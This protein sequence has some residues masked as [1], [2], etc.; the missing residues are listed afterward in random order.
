[1]IIVIVTRENRKGRPTNKYKK[2]K[3]SACVWGYYKE[4]GKVTLPT[5]KI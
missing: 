4:N 2:E 5:R 3:K 1:M